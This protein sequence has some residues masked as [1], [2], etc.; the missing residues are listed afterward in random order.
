MSASLRDS[1]QQLAAQF[2]DGVLGAIRGSSLEEVLAETVGGGRRGPGRPRKNPV[3]S[4]PAAVVRTA[5]RRRGGRLGRRSVK[6]LG[7]VVDRIAQLLASHPKGLRAE[8]IRARLGLS[9][10]EMPR[11]IAMALESKR[12]T[13]TGEKRATTYYAGGGRS[14]GGS[15]KTKMRAR[16]AKGRKGRRG[17]TV[18]RPVAKKRARRRRGRP[19]KAVAAAAAPATPAA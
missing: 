19:A 5:H 16:R 15:A 4:P 13:K 18:R 10:K 2:A 11:P 17:A 3:A 12:I 9:A 14:A 7:N 6:Q 8:Q 1:I